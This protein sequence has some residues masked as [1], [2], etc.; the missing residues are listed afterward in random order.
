MYINFHYKKIN[1][2]KNVGEIRVNLSDSIKTLKEKIKYTVGI[3]AE[4]QIIFIKGNK[5][6]NED[7]ILI[8]FMSCKEWIFDYK[9]GDIFVEERPKIPLFRNIIINY[10]RDPKKYPLKRIKVKVKGDFS[11]T[12]DVFK[13]R[14]KNDVGINPKDQVVY[15]FGK[16]ILDDEKKLINFLSKREIGFGFPV[17]AINVF[18]EKKKDEINLIIDYSKEGKSYRTNIKINRDFS[19]TIGELKKKIKD[20]VGIDPKDQILFIKLKPIPDDADK[21]SISS[22]LSTRDIVYGLNPGDVYVIKK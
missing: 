3:K 21:W 18:K 12:I 5:I 1:K 10:T 11:D 22:F 8:D 14:I 15:I 17:N 6:Y 19:N 13:N 9:L 20:V 2:I 4:D 16:K 7:K